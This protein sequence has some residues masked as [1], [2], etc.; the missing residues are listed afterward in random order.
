VRRSH[1]GHT[2][3]VATALHK[4]F[5]DRIVLDGLDLTLRADSR[6]VI[7]GPNGAGKTTLLR[8]LAGHD[9][10]DAGAVTRAPAVRIGFLD[11]E[12]ESLD[13]TMR[14]FDAYRRGLTGDLDSLRANLFRHGFFRHDD[15]Q[16]R[17]GELSLGQRRKLQLARLTAQHANVLLLDEPTNHLDLPT[18]EAFEAALSDF[19]GPILAIS[20]DRW[21]ITRF[22]K[23][24]YELRDGGL[25]AQPV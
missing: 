10:P 18:L 1:V 24:V 17:V 16:K 20:H 11:Q 25:T 8:I 14:V 23:E 7:S 2:P 13:P 9:A 4:S 5:G 3:L 19:A 22:A 21:F 6:V 12:Q 15:V